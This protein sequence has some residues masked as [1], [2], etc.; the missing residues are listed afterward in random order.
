MAKPAYTKETQAQVTPASALQELMDGNARFLKQS[1]AER[2]LIEQVEQTAQGQF[3][4]ATVLC[5][6]DSRIPVEIVFDQGVG[7]IFTARIA[8]NFVN[9]DILG[10]MEFASKLAGAKVIMVLG[11]TSCGAVKGACDHAKLGLL[12]QMLDKI[13]PAVNAVKTPEGTDRSSK[14]KAF[15]DEVAQVNVR[16]TVAAITERSSV[17]KDMV[18][19]GELMVVGAMYDVA[20]GK[21][22][23]VE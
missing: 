7:D 1:P 16:H 5:C 19:A 9:D 22:T 23:L 3:P 8:G 4:I 2:S 18:D 20:S 6:I 10:S 21:V 12:T 15:V 11:H 17:L 14:N 13:M